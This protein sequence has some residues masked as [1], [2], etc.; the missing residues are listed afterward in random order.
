MLN[1]NNIL[2]VMPPSKNRERITDLDR[3]N[4]RK[5]PY[6]ATFY[7]KKAAA[8]RRP[9]KNAKAFPKI[10]INYRFS[11]ENLIFSLARNCFDQDNHGDRQ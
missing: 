9:S 11:D 2:V 4:V 6:Q 10:L 8:H 3:L 5:E 1:I 7:R